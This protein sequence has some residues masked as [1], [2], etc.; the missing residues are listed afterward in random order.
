M[1]TIDDFIAQARTYLQVKWRH[2]G[3][4]RAGVDCVG[5]LYCVAQDLGM[6]VEDDT[7]YSQ[8]PGSERIVTKL[9]ERC[10]PVQV[11]DR[12]AGDVLLVS[13]AGEDPQHTMLMTSATHVIHASAAHRKVVEHGLDA[14]TIPKIRAAF[15]MRDAVNG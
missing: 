7:H 9:L 1:P 2:Q 11:K 5:L 15:R 10:D 13:V 14:A 12:R 3:R 6:L 4:S 8:R